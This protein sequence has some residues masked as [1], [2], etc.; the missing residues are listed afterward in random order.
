MSAGP[1]GTAPVAAGLFV[2][3]EEEEAASLPAGP[4]NLEEGVGLAAA[5]TEAEVAEGAAGEEEA[6]VSSCEGLLE[7]ALPPEEEEDS[8]VAPALSALSGESPSVALIAKSL[9]CE[10]DLPPCSEAQEQFAVQT[11]HDYVQ[12]SG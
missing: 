12:G 4:P 11:R 3:S 2:A 8:L 7:V 6:L 10:L 1:S 9:S 5:L